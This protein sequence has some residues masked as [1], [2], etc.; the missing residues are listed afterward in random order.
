MPRFRR[1]PV[2][3][4]RFSWVSDGADGAVG[5]G[6]GGGDMRTPSFGSFCRELLQTCGEAKMAELPRDEV[7]VKL[8]MK[9][10]RS[11]CFA[12]HAGPV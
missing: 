7:C 11:G 4:G 5:E 6:G 1:G 10:L 9:A 2:P 8:C 3:P 12:F